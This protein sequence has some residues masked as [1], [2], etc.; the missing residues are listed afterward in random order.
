MSPTLPMGMTP[1]RPFHLGPGEAPRPFPGFAH[2]PVSPHLQRPTTEQPFSGQLRLLNPLNDLSESEKEYVSDL[3]TLLQRVS[4]GWTQESL[5]PMEVDEML[6]NIEDIHSINRKLAK[7]LSDVM[8]SEDVTKEL[9]VVLIWFVDVMEAPYSNYCRTHVPHLDNWPE[10]INNSRLQNILSEIAAEQ[11]QHVTLDSFLMKPIDRLHYYRRLYM[12]LLDSSERGNPDFNTLE[13]AFMRVDTI[14]RLVTV[15]VPGTSNH[16]A[17]PSLS[18]VSSMSALRSALPSPPIKDQTSPK[19]PPQAKNPISPALPPSPMSPGMSPNHRPQQSA[20]NS[21]RTAE[22]MLELETSLDTSKVLDL[23][24]MQPK[25]CAL[26]LA[27]IEREVVIRGNFCFSISA[28]NGME[29]RFEDGHILLLSDLLLM[30]RTKT[31]QEIDSNSE[32][33]QSS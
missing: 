26:S 32:G 24:T 4:A 5:P 8:S 25:S 16:P 10:I 6:K 7:R 30:C 28:D 1:P 27:L 14:L 19:F 29:D 13:A 22:S 31:P 11:M 15:D 21:M 9:G 18:G 17:S 2:Q 3:K 20:S 23:F 12:R 33:N